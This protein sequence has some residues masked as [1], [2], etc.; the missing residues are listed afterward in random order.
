MTEI[1]GIIVTVL[2]SITGILLNR[3]VNSIDELKKIVE[4]IRIELSGK[5]AACV[6][7]HTALNG[8]VK[9]HEIKLNELNDK[10]EEH[11]K[12]ITILKTK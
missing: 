4:M 10:F 6:E 3:F 7:K 8:R 5:N 2:L 1:F 11:E 9:Q 12:E